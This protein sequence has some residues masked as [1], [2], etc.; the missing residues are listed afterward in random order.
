M[1]GR[2]CGTRRDFKLNLNNIDVFKTFVANMIVLK[3]YDAVITTATHLC[4]YKRETGT[5]GSP[6]QKM[7]GSL[8]RPLLHWVFARL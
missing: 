4:S 3:I 7:T 1:S 6:R 2:I 8:F 5:D